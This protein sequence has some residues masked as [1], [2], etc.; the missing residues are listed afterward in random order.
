M[1]SKRFCQKKYQNSDL[2]SPLRKKKKKKIQIMASYLSS[3]STENTESHV[4]TQK[5]TTELHIV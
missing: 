5:G 1:L 2:S 3:V 4:L